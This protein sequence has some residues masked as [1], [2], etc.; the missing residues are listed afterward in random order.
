MGLSALSK[1]WTC[2]LLEATTMSALSGWTRSTCG[3]RSHLASDRSSLTDLSKMRRVPEREGGNSRWEL[4][5]PPCEAIWA[6][7]CN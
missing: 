3:D 2:P 5:C 7:Y 6:R 1:T 4:F